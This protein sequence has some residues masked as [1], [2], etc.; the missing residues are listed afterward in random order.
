MAHGFSNASISGMESIF[1]RHIQ[2]FRSKIDEIAVSGDVVDL[3]EKIAYYAW[4][5]IGELAFS[6]QFDTQKADD[7]EKLPPI[8]NHIFLSSLYGS[9]SSLLP[10]SRNI[11][12]RLPVPW[13]QALLKSRAG[14][15]DITAKCVGACM[16]DRGKHTTH[17]LLT[18]LVEAKDPESGE[19]LDVADIASEAFAFVSVIT[20]SLHLKRAML[21]LPRVAGAHTTSGT[22]T[23][24][25]Y[26]LL[27]NPDIYKRVI[28]EVDGEVSGSTSGAVPY[29]GL[30][31]KL[32]YLGACMRENMRLTPVF[33]MPLSRILT[34]PTGIE[35]AGQVIPRGVSY[36]PRISSTCTDHCLDRC[37]NRQ[38]VPSAKPRHMGSRCK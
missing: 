31:N 11:T 10:H 20:S 24:L 3:K 9:A 4:D 33:T 36:I 30:E 27:S 18:Q 2:T 15:R 13:L 6:T 28:N 21:M 25:M 14:L 5:V 35:I 19:M 16:K 8:N 12:N 29:N 17:N 23:F 37:L 32:P 38:L 1:D 22:L 26:H 34:A 7:P